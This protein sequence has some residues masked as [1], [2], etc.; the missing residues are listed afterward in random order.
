MADQ[1]DGRSGGMAGQGDGATRGEWHAKGMAGRG[2]RLRGWQIRGEWQTGGW[3][4]LLPL[5]SKCFHLYGCENR[6]GGG[7]QA[8]VEEV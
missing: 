3:D 1:E 8:A 4:I 6:L 7:G 5:G 2:G